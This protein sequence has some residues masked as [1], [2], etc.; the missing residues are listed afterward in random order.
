MKKETP[1]KFQMMYIAIIIPICILKNISHYFK[2]SVEMSFGNMPF[3]YVWEET[4]MF[5]VT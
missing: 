2:L 4:K 1:N 5:G 3:L